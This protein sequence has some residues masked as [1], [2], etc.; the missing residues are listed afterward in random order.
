MEEK[1]KQILEKMKDWWKKFDRRQKGILLSAMSVVLIMVLILVLVLNHTTY[2]VLKEC[3]DTYM[4]SEIVTILEENGI[5]YRTSTDGM[6]VEVASEDLGTANVLLGANNIESKSYE[7][8]NVVDSSFTTTEADKQ[9]KMQKYAEGQ[10]EEDFEKNQ[11]H[12]FCKR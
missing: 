3:E 12:Q 10:M 11:Y 5:A 6:T 2:E 7:F 8:E 4:A 1:A 9:R